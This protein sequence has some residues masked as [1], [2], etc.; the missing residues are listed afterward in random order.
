MSWD[1]LRASVSNWDGVKAQFP[2]WNDADPGR[3]QAEAREVPEGL[4]AP[5]LPALPVEHERSR[6]CRSGRST[7][8]TS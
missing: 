2:T 6:A 3:V 8:A 7:S 1:N 5:E 4:A